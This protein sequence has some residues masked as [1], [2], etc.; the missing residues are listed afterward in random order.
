MT[1]LTAGYPTPDQTVDN[2][3]ALERGG[4]DVIELGKVYIIEG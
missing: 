1:F 4:V 3:L 2:L